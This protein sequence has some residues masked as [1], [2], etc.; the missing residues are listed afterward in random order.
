[1]AHNVPKTD[2]AAGQ[3]PVLAKT[4]ASL[5]LRP[6]QFSMTKFMEN[7]ALFP[8]PFARTVICST[9]CKHTLGNMQAKK[10]NLCI[11]FVKPKNLEFIALFEASGWSQAEAV[12]ES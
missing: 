10:H 12:R 9:Q 11:F 5:R 6:R 4:T 3:T 1:V 7:T 2:T 8:L